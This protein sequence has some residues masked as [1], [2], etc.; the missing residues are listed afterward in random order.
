MKDTG[1]AV[2]VNEGVDGN[3][4][5]AKTLGVVSR[6]VP[7]IVLSIPRLA[8]RE[9]VSST[10][11]PLPKTLAV[12]DKAQSLVATRLLSVQDRLKESDGHFAYPRRQI[13]K[14]DG[15]GFAFVPSP[16]GRSRL[17]VVFEG[18]ITSSIGSGQA[19]MIK[20]LGLSGNFRKW[21]NSRPVVFMVLAMVHLPIGGDMPPATHVS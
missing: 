18:H 2:V 14:Y 15:N 19:K 10:G 4:E 21:S 6:P 9:M 1:Q 12:F 3:R 11:G 17:Q 5:D 16:N 7:D 8:L 20:N 13:V